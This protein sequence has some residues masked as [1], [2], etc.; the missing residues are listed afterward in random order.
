MMIGGWE[1]ASCRESCALVSERERV[2]ERVAD[3]WVRG[4]EVWIAEWG[5]AT[6]KYRIVVRQQCMVRCTGW[7]RPIRCLKL[8]V[9][10]RKKI[11]NYRAFLQKMTYKDKAS[12]GSLPP[13]IH[14]VEYAYIISFFMRRMCAYTTTISKL[15]IFTLRITGQERELRL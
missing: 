5:I 1:I 10:L 15:C 12:Y 13:C 2:V 7:R 14:I 8:Q 9:I 11:T 4:C 6:C 3:W